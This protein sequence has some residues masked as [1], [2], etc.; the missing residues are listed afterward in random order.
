MS[1]SGLKSAR[2]REA[3]CPFVA[4]EQAAGR[5]LM[6][7]LRRYAELLRYPGVG[8]LTI[9]MFVGRLTAGMAALSILLLVEAGTGSVAAGGLATASYAV[10]LASLAPVG[11][12][13]I[14]RLGRRPILV[15]TGISYPVLMLLLVLSARSA[16][17]AWLL[18]VGTSA[19][20]G[21]A[22]PPTAACVRS[23]WPR[24]VPQDVLRTAY[25]L[26]AVFTDIVF[27]IGPLIVSVLVAVSGA[28]L[29]AGTA[30]ALA[31]I[32]ALGV[33]ATPIMRNGSEEPAPRSWAGPL[34]QPALLSVLTM[35]LVNSA[36]WGA[37]PVA[38]TVFTRQEQDPAA[39]GAILA[40]WSLGSIL[41][42]LWYGGRTWRIPPRRQYLWVLLAVSAGLAP[43]GLA[44]S[45]VQLAVLLG[46]GGLPVSSL[47]AVESYL[48][49]E[50]APAGSSAEAFTWMNTANYA[51][52]AA[53]S[54]VAGFV[55]GTPGKTPVMELPFVL[56]AIAC[57]VGLAVRRLV[58]RGPNPVAESAPNE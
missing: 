3:R 17:S 39:S 7:L 36:I 49:S 44:R 54:A 33:A 47:D 6:R 4:L 55:A 16:G 37:I 15:V 25:S 29:A 8:R 23:I 35:I 41:G 12:R 48:V 20:V 28:G 10:G 24:L 42:G 30:A 27:V 2:E 45:T 22:T 26:D 51:G 43:L 18:P 31:A 14:D 57:A 32:G 53:G 13:L 9:P 38:V 21:A 1:R 34:A 56:A 50:F 5:D 52:F 40:A 19:L 11:G 58:V 46:M